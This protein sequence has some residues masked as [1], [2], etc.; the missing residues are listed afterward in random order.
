MAPRVVRGEFDIVATSRLGLAVML[1][2]EDVHRGA[3]GGGVVLTTRP[4]RFAAQAILGTLAQL[5][6]G[7]IGLALLLVGHEAHLSLT[8]SA[9]AVSGFAIGMAVGRPLQGRAIDTIRPARVIAGCG[10]AHG[11]AYVLIAVAADERWPLAF[12]GFSLLA[13]IA[14]PPIATQMRASWPRDV[15]ADHATRMFAVISSLQTLSVLV[16]PVVFTL[17]NAT[18][19]AVTAMLTVAGISTVCTVLFAVAAA[20]EALGSSGD[21]RVGLR[22]YATALG[23]TAAV[24]VVN[25]TIE[26]AA[27]AIAIGAHHPG[28]AGPLV[29]TATL[30]TLLGA[31]GAM[32]RY[33]RRLP[34]IVVL[35]FGTVLQVLGC[36]VLLIPAPLVITAAG[37][38]VLGAGITPAYAA[39]SALVSQQAGGTAESFGWQSTAL[40]LGVAGG[41]ALAGALISPLGAHGSALLALVCAVIVLGATGRAGLRWRDARDA[42]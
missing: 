35:C 6:Q 40:G 37:L 4:P 19:S 7:I 32:S 34:S 26:V 33:G 22:R 16:A 11:L 21:V 24:G 2:D 17:V 8:T 41:S 5:T 15:A 20:G 14:L 10:V 12:V 42:G 3:G 28:A 27:P 9:L 29:A 13:G 18:A 25:G 31:L 1:R 36:I 30:G 23:L 38:L 39:L